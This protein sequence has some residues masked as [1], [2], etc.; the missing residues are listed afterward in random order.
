MVLALLMKE[1]NRE[2]ARKLGI[3]TVCMFTLPVIV[4]FIAHAIFADKKYPDSWAGGFAI[5]TVNI[6]I[7]AYVYSAFQEDDDDDDEND[8]KYPKVG[9]YKKRTD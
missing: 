4:F 9:I 6:I 3:A 5:V 8:D 2:V 1:E 7:A